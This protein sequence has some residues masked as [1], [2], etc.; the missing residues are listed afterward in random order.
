MLLYISLGCRKPLKLGGL[1]VPPENRVFRPN[2][3][4]FSVPP[5]RRPDGARGCHQDG[6]MRTLSPHAAVKTRLNDCTAL[7]RDRYGG[8]GGSNEEAWC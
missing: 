6:S 2:R 4:D 3:R 7:E 1:S 5:A 8:S